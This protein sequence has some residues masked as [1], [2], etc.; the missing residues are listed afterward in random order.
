MRVCVDTPV[1]RSVAYPS[2]SS[3]HCLST[4]ASL[5]R[6][7]A[8]QTCSRLNAL[9]GGRDSMPLPTLR[10]LLDQLG[11]PAWRGP[12]VAARIVYVSLSVTLSGGVTRRLRVSLRP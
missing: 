5:P 3:S 11:H 2:P 1:D 10:A 6:T 4:V 12:V 7:R 8:P 9:F